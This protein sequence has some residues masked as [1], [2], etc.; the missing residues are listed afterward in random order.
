M[1]RRQERKRGN[2]EE[3]SKKEKKERGHALHEEGG[4]SLPIGGRGGASSASLTVPPPSEQPA[5]KRQTR[6]HPPPSFSAAKCIPLMS[7]SHPP[8]LPP[9][10]RSRRGCLRLD[11]TSTQA[12]QASASLSTKRYAC[13]RP[14]ITHQGS[15]QRFPCNPSHTQTYAYTECIIIHAQPSPPSH[16]H[17]HT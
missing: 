4:L 16:T 17:T 13:R 9:L 3:T 7:F 2:E 10:T 15:A 12:R 14:A 8:S 5:L 6:R 11:S 1:R